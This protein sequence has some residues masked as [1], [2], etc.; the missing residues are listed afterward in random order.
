MAETAEAQVTPKIGD[1]RVWWI[2]QVP[3]QPF[4]VPVKSLAEARLILDTL[5]K[6]D[7]FQLE[8]RIK[9]DYTNTGGLEMFEGKYY[10]PGDT[11]WYDWGS[12]EGENID[13]I[14][15]EGLEAEDRLRTEDPYPWTYVTDQPRPP[16]GGQV[17]VSFFVGSNGP[18]VGS[19]R[20]ESGPWEFGGVSPSVEVYAWREHGPA[21]NPKAASPPEV[22]DAQG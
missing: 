11:G 10:E 19:A 8:N 6:Y 18:F 17:Q 20:R 4:H 16:H 22:A 21:A 13:E 14:S 3:A 2:P 12:S 5:A 15:P 9:G 7:L 1:L